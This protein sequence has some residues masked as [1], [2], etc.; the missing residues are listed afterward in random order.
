VTF[1]EDDVLSLRR[2]KRQKKGVCDREKEDQFR[3]SGTKYICEKK[4]LRYQEE[5]KHVVFKE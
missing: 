1:Y 5:R 4:K 3:E 2:E